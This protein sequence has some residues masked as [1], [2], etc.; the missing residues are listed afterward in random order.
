M[1]SS[2]FIYEVCGP[3]GEHIRFV[4]ELSELTKEEAKMLH[5]HVQGAG[6]MKYEA[7]AT[8]AGCACSRV[9]KAI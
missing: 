4:H 1:A 8:A 2:I 3:G 5:E 9:W 7:V 6:L